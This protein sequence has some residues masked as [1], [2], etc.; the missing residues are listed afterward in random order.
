LAKAAAPFHEGGW[1]EGTPTQQQKSLIASL[2]KTGWQDLPAEVA[3]VLNE[4]GQEAGT[5]IIASAGLI[6]DQDQWNAAEDE[7]AD[8]ALDRAGELVGLKWDEDSNQWIDNP[9]AEWRIDEDVRDELAKLVS[10]AEEEGWSNADL[11]GAIVESNLFS[12][13]RAELIARTELKYIDGMG[14]AAVAE[15]TGATQKKWMLS[16]NHDEQDDCDGNADEDWIGI[17]EDFPSGDDTVPAHPRCQCVVTYGW[18]D[19][20]GET[21]E[22]DEEEG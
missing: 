6:L 22:T 17:D 20:S 13:D 19:Q 12:E 14:A 11:R 7:V 8:I 3:P 5:E 2:L 16:A 10:Y 18:E 21:Q 1:G 15:R 4:E 9:N